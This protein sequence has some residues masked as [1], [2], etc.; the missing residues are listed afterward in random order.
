MNSTL[1]IPARRRA[2]RAF[3]LSLIMFGGVLLTPAFAAAPEQA[4]PIPAGQSRVWFLRQLLPGTIFTPPMVYV[5]GAPIA[6]SAEGTAFYRDFTPGQYQFTVENCLNQA[7]TSQ[8]MTL[9]PNAQ[10]AIEVQQDDNPSWD[11]YPAQISYLRQVQ[12]NDVMYL[13][14]PLTYLGPM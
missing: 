4:P 1:A 2:C 10:Y 3:V 9:K 13:F 14:S 8:T 11:C 7:N 5:N 6:R 12:P